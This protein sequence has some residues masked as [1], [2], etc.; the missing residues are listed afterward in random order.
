MRGP[1]LRRQPR[2]AAPPSVAEIAEAAARWF[3]RDLREM[4]PFPNLSDHAEMFVAI[5]YVAHDLC[6]YTQQKIAR[7]L[8]C[9]R[10]AVA[11]AA[12]RWRRDLNVEP[13][14][15]R[16][17]LG[18]EAETRSLRLLARAQSAAV[19]VSA[20][21]SAAQAFLARRGYVAP[22]LPVATIKRV[23]CDCYGLSAVDIDALNRKGEVS[24]PRQIAAFLA[25]EMTG[26]SEPAI[27]RA[28]GGRDPTTIRFAVKSIRRRAEASPA[29]AAQL[30]RLREAIEAAS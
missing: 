4:R 24:R 1:G 15:T 7:G 14:F 9:S 28:L 21:M 23:V 16:A 30:A 8:G 17:V 12:R 6:G 19:R 2:E 22:A 5:C 20:E 11:G 27:G 10:R 13:G 18:F 3:G 29:L 26:L 25:R